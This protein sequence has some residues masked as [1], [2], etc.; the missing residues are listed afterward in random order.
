MA[1]C[2]WFEHDGIANVVEPLGHERL[3]FETDFSHPTCS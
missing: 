2:F 3:L 1:L